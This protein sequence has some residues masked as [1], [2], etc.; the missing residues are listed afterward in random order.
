MSDECA[1]LVPPLGVHGRSLCSKWA[2][3]PA[4]LEAVHAFATGSELARP[5]R[6]ILRECSA[7]ADNPVWLLGPQLLREYPRARF[8]V[9]GLGSNLD[10]SG[11][12][13]V[14]N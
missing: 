11:A 6:S 4:S 2:G 10:G 8:I 13:E 3:S 7:V 12:P 14:K 5:L 1:A 9:S